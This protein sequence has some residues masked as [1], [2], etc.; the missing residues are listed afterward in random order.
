MHQLGNDGRVR[1]QVGR[2]FHP[3]DSE[4]SG[5]GYRIL[6]GGGFRESLAGR[7]SGCT[8]YSNILWPSKVAELY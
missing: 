8:T 7:A 4:V 2:D 3:V 6:S 1:C 5:F